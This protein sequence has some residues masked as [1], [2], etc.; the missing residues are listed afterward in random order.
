[1]PVIKID[2]HRLQS[3]DGESVLDTLIKHDIE[4]PY[5]C[6]IGICQSCKLHCTQGDIPEQSQ[7]ALEPNLRELGYFLACQ[8]VPENDIQIEIPGSKQLYIS[9]ELIDKRQLSPEVF[10]FRL[11]TNV[12]IFYHAGQFINLRHNDNLIRSYSLASLPSEDNLL[13]LH[14][15]RMRNGVVSNWLADSFEIG[16]FIEIEGPMGA[17][18]YSNTMNNQPLLLIGTGTG[19]APLIGIIRDALHNKHQGEI[20]LYHGAYSQQELYLNAHLEKLMTENINLKYHPCITDNEPEEST[21]KELAC[22]IALSNHPDL[23]GWQVF[24]CGSPSMVKTMQQK[25]YFAGASLADIHTDPFET[26]ELRN[27]ERG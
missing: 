14:V 2:N 4:V 20:H 21:Q 12:P 8:C 27:Q 13:E 22:N 26:K 3:G 5:S 25:A 11:R 9:A 15:K 23:K 19:L 7:T 24:L 6:K 17:C 1:M 16:E 18:F 10:R